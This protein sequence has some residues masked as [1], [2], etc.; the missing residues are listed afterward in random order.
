MVN[1]HQHT[2]TWHVDD[3]KSSHV[4]ETVDDDFLHWLKAT[5]ASDGTGELKVTRG[6]RHNYLAM[7]HD[8]TVP[9]FCKDS[10]GYKIPME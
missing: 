2:I 1:G 4:D 8:Y 5:H 6:L 9:G 10:W 3:V 7:T